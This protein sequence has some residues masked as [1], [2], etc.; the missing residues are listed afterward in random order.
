MK[1]IKVLSSLLCLCLSV[2]LSLSQ[3]ANLNL[4][5]TPLFLG[6]HI[7][8]NIFFELDDSGSMDWEVLARPHWHYCAYDPDAGSYNNSNSSCGWLVENGLI[9]IYTGSGYEYFEYMF[10][11]SDDAYTNSCNSSRQT[12]EMCNSSDMDEEW[13]AKSS[14]LNV[15]YYNPA[16]N[17][18]PW[19]A[20]GM[21]DADFNNVKSDP[22]PSS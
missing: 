2:S 9:R 11:N 4:S 22:E 10:D 14:A 18:K 1:K 8:P 17:Y 3:A 6:S 5:N 21:T 12:Y 16:V 13:R 19:L 7:Q 15:T 20:S